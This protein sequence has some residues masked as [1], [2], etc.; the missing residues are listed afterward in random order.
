MPRR[1][2]RS[3]RNS[4]TPRMKTAWMGGIQDPFSLAPSGQA[5]TNLTAMLPDTTEDP[6]RKQELTLLRVHANLRMNSSDANLSVDASFGLI[7]VDGDALA[8][9]AL[10]DPDTDPEA[11]WLHW[12][13]RSFL[14]A[15]DAQQQIQLDIKA[16]RRFRG[17]DANL[18]A[19][20]DNTDAAQTLDVQFSFRL[21]LGFR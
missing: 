18:V 12:L 6:I 10:P 15:S 16:R 2:Y 20:W 3:S 19:I 13:A 4:G 11:S 8:A 5:F 17:N 9:Q 7:M 14:P 21:L 1:R